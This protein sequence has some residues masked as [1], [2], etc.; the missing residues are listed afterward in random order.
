MKLRDRLIIAFVLMSVVP[1]IVMAILEFNADRRVIVEEVEN[2]L[3]ST[4]ILKSNELDRWVKD[5]ENSLEEL[6]QRPLIRDYTAILTLKEFDPSSYSQAQEELLYNHLSPRLRYG[7]FYEIFIMNPLNGEIMISTD[8]Q[9]NGENRA[10]RDYFTAGRD[11]THVEG[12]YYS[13]N[14]NQPAMTIGTPIRGDNGE[15]IGVMAGRLELDEL[16]R[17]ME[18]QSGLSQTEDTYLVNTSNF[19]VTEPR[20]GDSFAMH[21]TVQT[22]GVI[23]GLAGEDGI[24]LYDNYRGIPVIGAYKWLPEYQMCLVTEIDQ[25][26]AFAP[27][28]NTGKILVGVVCGVVVLLIIA[29][30]FIARNIVSPVK[31]LARGAEIIGAGN[32][33][34]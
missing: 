17:I 20:F 2:H 11:N 15:L 21:K 19:F 5:N 16:S 7:G 22:E 30:Y 29:A 25:S 32:L 12:V 34:C 31:E 9:S 26:E 6:A 3:I 18:E 13:V 27:I 28:E 24:A 23:A 8:G 14:L 33:E 1:I 4:N 10:Y